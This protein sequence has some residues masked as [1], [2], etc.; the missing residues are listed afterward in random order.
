MTKKSQGRVQRDRAKKMQAQQANGQAPKPQVAV[1]PYRP[2]NLGAFKATENGGYKLTVADR[3]L[4]ECRQ[5]LGVQSTQPKN[6]CWDDLT[7]VYRECAAMLY[8]HTLISQL[9][10]DKDLLSYVDDLPQFNLN[11]KQFAEDLTQMSVELQQLYALHSDKTGGS[12]DADVVLHSFAVYEQYKLW[13]TKHD[14]VVKPTIMHILE[15]TNQAELRRAEVHQKAS[16]G[17]L[18]AEVP[19]E[20]VDPA[21]LD[22][23]TVTDVQ[24]QDVVPAEQAVVNQNAKPLRGQSSPIFH[25]D[26]L[27]L[28]KDESVPA[29][30]DAME[31]ASTHTHHPQHHKHEHHAS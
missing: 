31:P 19:Q 20:Q 4:A 16:E 24:F 11:V 27:G 21:V 30:P 23:S 18:N 26:E 29:Q 1:K 14:G 3:I 22:V 28:F 12:D 2:A 17:L 15:Q 5:G 7:E 13:M 9:L 6:T 8:Q 10:N 25:A